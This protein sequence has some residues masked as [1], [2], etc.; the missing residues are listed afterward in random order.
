[1]LSASLEGIAFDRGEHGREQGVGLTAERGEPRVPADEMAELMRNAGAELVYREYV[2]ERS[3]DDE[4]PAR[5]EDTTNFGHC[6]VWQP[7]EV[8]LC[9]RRGA[10]AGRKL[11]H[12]AE[13]QWRFFPEQGATGRDERRAPG[14][15]RADDQED[16][17]QPAH[18]NQKQDSQTERRRDEDAHQGADEEHRRRAEQHQVEP[19]EQGKRQRG[20]CKG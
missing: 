7:I 1:M 9:R 19:D 20:A 4:H 15:Q 10:G 5:S 16:R 11:V 8:N 18:R 13:Q 2:K 17:G 12:R 14:L 3:A 6:E